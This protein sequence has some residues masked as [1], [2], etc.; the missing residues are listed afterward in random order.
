MF[1][2]D[3]WVYLV[4]ILIYVVLAALIILTVMLALWSFISLGRR[5]FKK[6]I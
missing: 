1:N 5:I 3:Y 4:V 2:S 6:K